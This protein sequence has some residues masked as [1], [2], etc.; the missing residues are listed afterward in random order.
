MGNELVFLLSVV[1][2][3]GNH[4]DTNGK[5]YDTPIYSR[6]LP[7]QI[8]E[9]EIEIRTFEGHYYHSNSE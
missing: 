3:T 4:A 9:L 6:V 7:N 5:I 1:A 2:V 8:Q